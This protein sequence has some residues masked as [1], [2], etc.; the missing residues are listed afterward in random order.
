MHSETVLTEIRRHPRGIWIRE[1]ARKS[2]VSPATV[3]NYLYGYHDR[4]GN[5]VKP[6]LKKYVKLK[7]LGNSSLTLVFPK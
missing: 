6:V 7:K 1:L 5:F 2:K 3:C 4:A